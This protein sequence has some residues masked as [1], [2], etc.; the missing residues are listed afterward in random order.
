MNKLFRATLLALTLTTGLTSVAQAVE[1]AAVP[2]PTQDPIVRHLKLTDEQVTK[3]K[4]LHQQFEESASGIQLEGFKDGAITDMFRSGK[5]DDAAV[6]KQLAAFS[7]YDQ[8][9]RYYRVKY[10][11]GINKVLTPEQRQQVKS[12]I[13]SALN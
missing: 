9:L 2:A 11:F 10:Y 5:W 13:L 1:V 3:I 8:Q 4:A 7:Q 6:K 12:D